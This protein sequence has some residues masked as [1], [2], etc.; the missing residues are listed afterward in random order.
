MLA[1]LAVV[2]L[3]LA[4]VTAAGGA[5]LAGPLAQDSPLTPQEQLSPLPTDAPRVEPAQPA[6]T[7]TPAPEPQPDA[8]TA[9]QP[10]VPIEVLI[11]AMVVLGLAALVISLRRRYSDPG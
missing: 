8:P 1:A 4:W 7:A 6:S 3:A 9:A 2:A 10:P 5:A 11:G